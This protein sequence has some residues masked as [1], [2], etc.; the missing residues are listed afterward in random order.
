MQSRQPEGIPAGGQWS[1]ASKAESDVDLKSPYDEAVDRASDEQG[2]TPILSALEEK[3]LSSYADQTGGFTMVAT[4]PTRARHICITDDSSPGNPSFILAQPT[5]EE[6]EEGEEGDY[7]VFTTIEGAAARAKEIYDRDTVRHGALF[8]PATAQKGDPVQI[9]PDAS[10]S[11][12][13]GTWTYDGPT[14]HPYSSVIR[15]TETG[16]VVDR[17][18]SA[19]A[20]RGT[21]L[22]DLSVD[23]SLVM[24]DS[25]HEA[26]DGTFYARTS[27]QVI[28][29]EGDPFD[30]AARV[31]GRYSYKD[32]T[33]YAGTG[34]RGGAVVESPT[35]AEEGLRAAYTEQ[36]K[37]ELVARADKGVLNAT[38]EDAV[39]TR[40]VRLRKRGVEIDDPKS[41]NAS[42]RS[43]VD[44]LVATRG[45]GQA[46]VMVAEAT[47]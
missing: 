2:I 23:S 31:V 21:T 32:R 24:T 22:Y 27:D 17:N 28:L 11:T 9:L 14:R 12:L 45:L 33:A 34:T 5:H 39:A 8:D 41:I 47:S 4:V 15:N 16:T 37:S 1:T 25:S 19:L 42:V 43:Q 20:S 7:E 26:P 30:K 35:Y 6:I 46:R 38:I 18:N 10:G 44:Y 29:V 3:G 40:N 13:G 36:I